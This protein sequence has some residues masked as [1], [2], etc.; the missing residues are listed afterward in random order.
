MM[1]HRMTIVESDF[2]LKSVPLVSG[3]R[4]PQF[5][6][7]R[8]A[9]PALSPTHDTC[10]L[11]PTPP[12]SPAKAIVA[13]RL[14]VISEANFALPT[15][16]AASAPAGAFFATLGQGLAPEQTFGGARRAADRPSASRAP[17]MSA[18]ERRTY[19]QLHDIVE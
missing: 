4:L 7:R 2:P 19:A 12:P 10:S 14:L 9:V 8:R 1:Q 6:A 15:P 18:D 16:P 5:T 3:A 13:R 11:P 17:H